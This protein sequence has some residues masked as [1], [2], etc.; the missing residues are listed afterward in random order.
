MLVPSGSR[1]GN[2]QVSQTL[3][4]RIRRLTGRDPAVCV[5]L[6]ATAG[7]LDTRKSPRRTCAGNEPERA[8]LV[9]S[10]E[11]GSL[12]EQLLRPAPTSAPPP[13][14]PRPHTLLCNASPT[15]RAKTFH[16]RAWKARR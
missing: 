2:T 9:R 13:S 5:T 16:S 7:K 12:S 15:L 14:P 8:P 4:Q 1:T 11:H 6:S 3:P 10:V